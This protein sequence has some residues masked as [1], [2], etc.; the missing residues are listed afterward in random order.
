LCTKKEPEDGFDNILNDIHYTFINIRIYNRFMKK[1]L[2]ILGH[3]RVK[4]YNGALAD[5]YVKG[6]KKSGAQVKRINLRDLRFDPIL[7]EGYAKIQELE[8]D[9]VQAQKDILWAEHLV[10]IFPTWWAT[11]PA[12]LKGFIDRIF[13]PGFAFKYR[14]DFPWWDK[15]LKGK[16]ARIIVTM[17]APYLYYKFFIGSPGIKMLKRGVLQFSGVK[18][19]KITPIGQIRFLTGEKAK[20][21]LKKIEV[22]GMKEGK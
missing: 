6:A 1:I 2:V 5:S 17:D 3:P 14:K 11:I 20:K 15:Y 18:P 4:S 7:W 16:S 10:F 21:W 22:L 13:L 9:L 12:L 19:V 8:E